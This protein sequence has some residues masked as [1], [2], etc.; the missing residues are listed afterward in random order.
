MRAKETEMIHDWGFLG[1]WGI[2]LGVARCKRCGCV[3]TDKTVNRTC[4]GR[5]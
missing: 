2:I 1:A 3:A 4:S 5:T